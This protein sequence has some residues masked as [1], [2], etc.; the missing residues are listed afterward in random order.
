MIHASKNRVGEIFLTPS[1]AKKIED[2]TE[3]LES[4]NAFSSDEVVWLT[5]CKLIDRVFFVTFLF[6]YFLMIVTLLPEG[7]LKASYVPIE[8]A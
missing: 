5:F 2:A 8:N 6:L 4:A 3:L 1:S 7:Y